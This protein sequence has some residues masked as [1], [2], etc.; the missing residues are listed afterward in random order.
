MKD[1][2]NFKG[3]YADEEGNIY[4]DRI[5]YLRKIPQ[6]LHKGYYR[7][8]IRDNNRPA[9][10]YTKSVH[11]LILNTFVGER[12]EG[13]LCRHLNGN[14]LDNRLCNLKWGTPKENYEDAV[15]HG[16][17]IS[18][19][20]GEEH[21]HAKLKLQDIYDI[22][23]MHKQG[24]IEREIAEKYSISQ[25]HVS[26]IVLGRTWKEKAPLNEAG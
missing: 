1:I 9:K 8:N 15:R 6:R 5:G 25:K 19:R 7:V 22:R 26:D 21:P 16:T 3:Y 4:S 17:A 24:Y 18:L 14:A 20:L 11:T 2:P 10:L 13:M 12:P 23:E